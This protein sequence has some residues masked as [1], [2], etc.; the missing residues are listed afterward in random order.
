MFGCQL[1][2]DIFIKAPLAAIR[3]GVLDKARRALFVI[4]SNPATVERYDLAAEL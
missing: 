2:H 3:A 1:Q 4:E